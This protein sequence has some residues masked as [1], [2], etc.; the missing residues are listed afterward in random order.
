MLYTTIRCFVVTPLFLYRLVVVN[1]V[2]EEWYEGGVKEECNEGGVRE[3]CSDTALSTS[4][5]LLFLF[6]FLLYFIISYPILYFLFPYTR[7]IVSIHTIFHQYPSMLRLICLYF[8]CI[9]PVLSK[10]MGLM[11]AALKPENKEN[12]LDV[13]TLAKI[14]KPFLYRRDASFSYGDVAVSLSQRSSEGNFR[15]NGSVNEFSKSGSTD[16]MST[17]GNSINIDSNSNNNNN[18]NNNSNN[19]NNDSNNNS[20][21]NINLNSR[22]NNNNTI[23]SSGSSSGSGSVSGSA[24]KMV[25]IREKGDFSGTISTS[26]GFRAG[27][28]SPRSKSI[29][30]TGERKRD[31][32]G[33]GGRGEERV[34]KEGEE[35]ERREG[36]QRKEEEM[37]I[38]VCL[39][40]RE[41]KRKRRD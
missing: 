32:R 35:R 41:R 18:N 30:F 29:G 31:G 33:M 40:S 17:T 3:E 22:S 1:V 38:S 5:L 37:V 36:K 9:R 28:G 13:K 27:T 15:K 20:N 8:P 24:K 23:N 2:K 26:L 39:F 6:L 25:V 19:S 16:N 4:I 14:C 7:P 21:N 12:G 10:I 11:S 34:V